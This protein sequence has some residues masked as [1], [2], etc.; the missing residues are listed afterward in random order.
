M[1]EPTE[2]LLNDYDSNLKGIS[3]LIVYPCFIYLHEVTK[4]S[5][6]DFHSAQQNPTPVLYRLALQG[7]QI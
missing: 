4:A 2:G 1:A 7:K 6:L 5:C 3:T